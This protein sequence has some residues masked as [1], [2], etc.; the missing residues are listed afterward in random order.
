MGKTPLWGKPLN[1]LYYEKLKKREAGHEA[2][3]KNGKEE[4]PGDR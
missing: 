1:I 3:K 4:N 2:L